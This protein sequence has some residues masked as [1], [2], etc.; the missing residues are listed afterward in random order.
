MGIKS[1]SCTFTEANIEWT[2][3]ALLPTLIAWQEDKYEEEKKCWRQSLARVCSENESRRRQRERHGNK[4]NRQHMKNANTCALLTIRF[5]GH[6]RSQHSIVPK[7]RNLPNELWHTIQ[8]NPHNQYWATFIK[9][10]EDFQGKKAILGFSRTS[11]MCITIARVFNGF[12]DL[13]TP[14]L[15]YTSHITISSDK[16]SAAQLPHTYTSFMS[17]FK[18]QNAACLSNIVPFT[19]TFEA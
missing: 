17:S 4:T 5:W 16:V 12:K 7:K 6:V 18:L 19:K 3:A 1:L 2:S 13:Y 8:K 9:K 10:F 11:K 14:C 15:S